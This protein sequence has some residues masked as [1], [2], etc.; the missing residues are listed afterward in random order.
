MYAWLNFQKDEN[1][2]KSA[3]KEDIK[4]FIEKMQYEELPAES[5]FGGW[6]TTELRENFIKNNCL[7]KLKEIYLSNH[8]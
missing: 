3:S 7:N 6:A 8:K 2:K 5:I 1:L 4:S